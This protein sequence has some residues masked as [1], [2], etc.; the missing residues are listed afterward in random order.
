MRRYSGENSDRYQNEH[1]EFF[2]GIRSGKLINKGDRMAQSTLMG[3]SFVVD[4]PT[5]LEKSQLWCMNGRKA[6]PLCGS[7]MIASS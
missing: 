1:N 7:K 5:R 3:H 2:A 4:S 6:L